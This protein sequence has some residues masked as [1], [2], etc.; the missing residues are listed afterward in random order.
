MVVL[1]PFTFGDVHFL[2]FFSTFQKLNFIFGGV[3]QIKNVLVVIYRN[4]FSKVRTS[5]PLV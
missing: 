5:V 3:V 4:E 1:R 2:D